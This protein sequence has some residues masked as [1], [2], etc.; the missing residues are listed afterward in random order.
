MQRVYHHLSG[1][2][3]GELTV[4]RA[5]FMILPPSMTRISL[6]ANNIRVRNPFFRF[7]QPRVDRL[8]C[9]WFVPVLLLL[10]GCQSAAP[11]AHGGLQI[12]AAETFLADIA[13]NVAGNRFQV[14]SLIPLGLDPHGF[15]PTPAD[16]ARLE[17]CDMLII[18]GG[19]IETWLPSLQSTIGGLDKILDAS[20]GIPS[21][22]MPDGTQGDD[23]HFWLDPTLVIRYVENIRDRFSQID[24][25]GQSAF[26]ANAD[27]YIQ[28]LRSL[29][30]WIQSSVAAIPAERRILVTN[31]D[32]LGYF[33]D[34]YGFRILGTLIPS[35]S[36][37]SEPSAQQLAQL[38]D[39]M[40]S[41]GAKAIFLDA[42]SNRQLA[43]Q[44]ARET[45]ATVVADLY[46]HSLSAPGGDAPTYIEM[47]RR[48]VER[49][50]AALQ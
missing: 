25:A 49:I 8:S 13:N 6:F 30:Q 5:P 46:V 43:D 29:D 38:V 31:H 47:M 19:G 50:V 17:R 7:N 35:T 41:S 18:N 10:S 32:S 12:L 27:L 40:R 14:D 11:A 20:R 2:E 34:R 22:A 42:G 36:S 16:A 24:P 21:R 9:L 45:G 26:T 44:M 48:N 28:Q 15:E 23:P 33:A 37:G 3:V 39:I 4:M 1:F